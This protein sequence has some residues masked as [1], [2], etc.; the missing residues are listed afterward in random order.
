MGSPPQRREKC[1]VYVVERHP[2]AA[3]HLAMILSANRALEV[4][5]SDVD[6]RAN[7]TL[8]RRISVLVIDGGALPFPLAAFLRTAR[9]VFADAPTLVIGNRLS[10][11]DL[12]RLLFHGVKGCITYDKV[13]Q[14]LS[15]AVEALVTGRV[16]A[17]RRVLER[18]VMLSSAT[19]N[20]KRGEHDA[21]SPRES[22]V[23]GLL[24]RRLSNKEIGGALGISERTVRFH[25]QNIFAKL[26][27]HD[28][29]SIVEL[30]QGAD[31]TESHEE[32]PVRKT[33]VSRMSSR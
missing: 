23:M 10:D 19:A 26:G 14:E 24:Q 29:Y 6:L 28:R 21:F 18:Y 4:V 33:A 16:W 12:C 1:L 5:L 31:R 9:T 2:I 30:A 20:D 13:E 15:A 7:P 3:R 17:P 8:S 11:E 32:A 25:L 22:E 27:V